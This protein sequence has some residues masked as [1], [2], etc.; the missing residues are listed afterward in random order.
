MHATSNGEA[1]SAGIGPVSGATP[2]PGQCLHQ[3]TLDMGTTS[4]SKLLAVARAIAACSVSHREQCV[5]MAHLL[6]ITCVLV[7][8]MVL[9]SGSCT[10]W[11]VHGALAQPAA[12]I[13]PSLHL[14]LQH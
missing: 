8:M 9:T 14:V 4:I 6:A 11:V 13:A 10:L 5:W 7:L 3:D 2:C 12:M 1:L